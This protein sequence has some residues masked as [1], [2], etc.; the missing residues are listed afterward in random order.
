M[1][2]FSAL[3]ALCAT[4]TGYRYATPF[5]STWPSS[6]SSHIKIG[7][8]SDGSH[9]IKRVLYIGIKRLCFVRGIYRSPVNSPHIG[10]WRTALMFSLICALINDWVNNREAGDFRRH[11]AHYDVTVIIPNSLRFKCRYHKYL[12]M[13]S[14]FGHYHAYKQPKHPKLT[15]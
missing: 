12:Y 10:Q 5:Y 9:R 13:V 3:L 14:K 2:T 1:E 8:E 7:E 4:V 11:R 6:F 15:F